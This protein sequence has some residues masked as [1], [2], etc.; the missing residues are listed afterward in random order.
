LLANQRAAAPADPQLGAQALAMGA[1]IR[2]L[3]RA[4]ALAM[5]LQ[6]ACRW[7]VDATPFREWARLA[8]RAAASGSAWRWPHQ[9]TPAGLTN[10]ATQSEGKARTVSGRVTA[11]DIR[12][13]G[14]KAISTVTIEQDGLSI[15]AVLPFIKADSGGIVPGAWCRV[16]GTWRNTSSEAIGPALEIDR[17]ALRDLAREGWD[18]AISVGVSPIFTAVPHGLAA[19]WSWQPGTDGAGNQLRYG[20]WLSGREG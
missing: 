14:R 13:R 20:T 4:V 7:P 2:R 18:E 9:T 5:A 17:L 11:V 6:S 12:H 15:E 16:A 3:L 8:E 1:L 19:E 10:T